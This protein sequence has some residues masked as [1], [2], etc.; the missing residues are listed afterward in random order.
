[1]KN[2]CINYETECDN[3]YIC[4]CLAYENNDETP[5]NMSLEIF[6]DGTVSLNGIRITTNKPNGFINVVSKYNV[7]R[8]TIQKILN[9][10]Y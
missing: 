3:A 6:S 5:Q 7:D 4:P 8:E 2:K 9:G 1:M 10:Y